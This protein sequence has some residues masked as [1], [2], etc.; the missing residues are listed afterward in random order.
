[1]GSTRTSESKRSGCA[2]AARALRFAR[3]FSD[4][5]EEEGCLSLQDGAAEGVADPDEPAPPCFA[6]LVW[7]YGVQDGVERSAWIWG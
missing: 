5:Q 4:V 7:R 2:S 6:E 3:G 1:M